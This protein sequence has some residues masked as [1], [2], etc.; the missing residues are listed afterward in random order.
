M[1]AGQAAGTHCALS[2]FCIGIATQ[3]AVVN[4][5]ESGE[6]LRLPIQGVNLLGAGV[7][8]RQSRLVRCEA[9]PEASIQ[10][11]ALDSLKVGHFFYPAIVY[12]DAHY[13]IAR[14]VL[15]KVDLAA[16]P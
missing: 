2:E 7:A 9:E 14:R 8:Q 11:G 6:V 5:I 3:R 1:W 12:T 15:L 16:I 10:S 13:E 4:W